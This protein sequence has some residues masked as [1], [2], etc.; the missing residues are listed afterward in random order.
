VR[1]IDTPRTTK[2]RH[3]AP[4]Q[5]PSTAALQ[6]LYDRL[7]DAYG[8]QS[9]WPAGT[10]LEMVLGAL[11]VQNTAWTSARK[12]LDNLAAAGKQHPAALLAAPEAEIAELIRPS[13]YFNSKARK[14]KAFAQM[15][16]DQT[17]G[18]L[19]ALLAKP[20]DELRPLLLAT[21]GFGPETADAVCLFAARHPTFVIDAYTRRI[22]DR[23]DLVTDNPSYAALRAMFMDALPLQVPLY[24][25]Y[26]GLLVVHAK[27]TCT[28]K[29]QCGMCPLI[30]LCPTGQAETGLV[31]MRATDAE[32]APAENMAADWNG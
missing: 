7:L 32:T 17:D 26:H 9:W 16:D 30:D 28:K 3:S 20:L 31:A 1:G 29:P 8:P 14:L 10:E 11:L 5:Q 27:Q 18:D 23:L 2:K 15:L 21:H 24:A 25:E 19:N 4:P 22:L 13:G 6:Q 12:A